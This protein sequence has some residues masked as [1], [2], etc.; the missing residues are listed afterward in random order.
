GGVV[1]VHD[2]LQERAHQPH[3]RSD[4]DDG[5]GEH[6]AEHEGLLPESNQLFEGHPPTAP[7]QPAPPAPPAPP[8]EVPPVG[9]PL[10][11]RGRQLGTA[12]VR[13]SAG[14]QRST[15]SSPPRSSLAGVH[16]RLPLQS[17]LP[18]S[19]E[20]RSPSPWREQPPLANAT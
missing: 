19:R 10:P 4:P 12:S 6:H 16:T 7:R 1:D 18:F 5:E 11:V 15:R 3:E 9:A 20:H 14:Q 2:A 8:L 13:S 17:S